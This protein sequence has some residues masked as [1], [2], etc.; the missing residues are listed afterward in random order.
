MTIKSKLYR[1]SA[2]CLAC[3]MLLTSIVG[4]MD[5]HYCGGHVKSLNFFGKAKACYEM[6]TAKQCPNHP[7]KKDTVATHHDTDKNNC[8]SNKSFLFQ[9]DQDQVSQSASFV[10]SPPLQQF[11]TTYVYT[12]LFGASI[13]EANLPCF[14]HYKVP[15]FSRDYSVLFQSFLI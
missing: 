13:I 15:L 1:F 3:L 5:I 7:K 10:L 9:A 2:L 4:V 12:L 6:V 8:C 11:V 14:L